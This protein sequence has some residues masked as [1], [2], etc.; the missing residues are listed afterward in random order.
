MRRGVLGGRT[1]GAR[2]ALE[3]RGVAAVMCQIPTRGEEE[4][5]LDSSLL[6]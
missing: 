6:F 3:P 4:S 2:L 1:A 5:E